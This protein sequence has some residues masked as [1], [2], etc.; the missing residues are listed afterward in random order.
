MFSVETEVKK[1]CAELR[2]LCRRVAPVQV[3]HLP[4]LRDTSTRKSFSW[5]AKTWRSESGCAVITHLH[6]EQSSS[7][8]TPPPPQQQQ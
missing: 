6:R 5:N 8:V 7:T 4:P 3:Q 2:S 1:M